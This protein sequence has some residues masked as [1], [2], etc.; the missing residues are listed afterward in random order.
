MLRKPIAN[1]YLEQSALIDISK[2]ILIYRNLH[3]HKFSVKQGNVRFHTDDIWMTDCTFP[4]NE[5]IRQ[6]VI[7]IGQKEVHAYIKGFLAPFSTCSIL[8]EITYNPYKA[9]YFVMGNTEMT[10]SPCV[11]ARTTPDKCLVFAAENSEKI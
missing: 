3:T 2:P 11:H 5:R 8:R 1:R 6:K 7:S 10:F 4:V 9:G